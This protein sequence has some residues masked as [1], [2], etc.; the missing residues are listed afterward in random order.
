MLGPE[1]P[2]DATATWTGKTVKKLRRN[3][4]TSQKKKKKSRLF[5]FC[6]AH[7]PHTPLHFIQYTYFTHTQLII[8][9]PSESVPELDQTQ[10]THPGLPPKQH[11]RLGSYR[12]GRALRTRGCRLHGP[13]IGETAG[14]GAFR[15]RVPLGSFVAAM[16]NCLDDELYRTAAVRGGAKSLRR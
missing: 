11:V 4:K 16:P 3:W 9:P 5:L 7:I 15:T 8:T 10:R 1:Q 14:I 13:L 12:V 6:L 2:K